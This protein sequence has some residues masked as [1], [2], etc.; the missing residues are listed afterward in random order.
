MILKVAEILTVK[1]GTGAIVEYFGPGAESLSATGKATICNMGAEIGATTSV[2]AYDAA[3]ARYLKATDR[4]AIA[5]AADE[6][7]QELR[8]DP[9]VYDDPQG[10]YDEVIE[11]DLRDLEPLING[12]HT[13][14][15]ARPVSRLGA[16][17]EGEGWPL[18]I[19]AA[20]VGSCTNSSY[21]DITRAASIARL[22]VGEGPEGQD[23]ADGHAWLGARARHDRPRRP[24]RRPRS[25]RRGRARQRVRAVHRAVGTRPTSKRAMST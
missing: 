20:L 19:S 15:R 4:E 18:Q 13:P 2:F 17:A 7:A 1:G 6:V 16:E 12:P 24:A 23:E 21:E 3:M 25:D 14:D 5:D 9:E 22:A 10:F 8:S 11:I